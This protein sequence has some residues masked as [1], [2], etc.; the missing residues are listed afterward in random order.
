MLDYKISYESSSYQ[1]I[2]E[3]MSDIDFVL[4][5]EP[6]S[7]SDIKVGVGF[8][9]RPIEMENTVEVKRHI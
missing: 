2:D 5:E 4:G 7:N 1:D 3:M 9:F 6:C 8:S